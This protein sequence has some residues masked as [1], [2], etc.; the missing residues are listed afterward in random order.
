MQKQKR[1]MTTTQKVLH[2]KFMTKHKIKVSYSF[3]CKHRPFW[4]LAPKSAQRDTCKCII[5][6]NIDLMIKALKISSIIDEPDCDALIKNMCCSI[7]EEKCL[8]RE[9]QYCK[10]K[11]V[12]F[13]E[14]S[15]NHHITYCKWIRARETVKTRKGLNVITVMKKEEV[16]ATP[17]ELINVLIAS[18]R[19]FF[20][21]IYKIHNQYI[22]LKKLKDSTPV[23]CA[24]IHADFSENYGL[25]FNKEV[26][27]MHFGGSR[28][29]ISLHTA[30]I[31]SFDFATSSARPKSICTTSSCLRHD[32]PAAWA[33]FVPLIQKTITDNPFIDTLHIQ[34][35]SPT[36]QY[37]NKYI[38]HMITQ[39]HKEFAQINT[40]TWNYTETGHGKGAADGVG[41]TIK[42]TVDSCVNHGIDVG[43]YDKFMQVCRENIK[44]ITLIDVPE[45]KIIDKENKMPKNLLPFRGTL[46]VHQVLWKKGLSM[47]T[48]RNASCFE[49]DCGIICAHGK[50]LGFLDI[51]QSLSSSPITDTD[52]VTPLIATKRYYGNEVFANITNT[53]QRSTPIEANVSIVARPSNIKILQNKRI[54]M[55]E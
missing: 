1:Y 55:T 15:D 48:L 6:E 35:D 36:S 44:N 27:S 14:F 4:V 16:K 11:L 29:E 12:Q 10:D 34:T 28:K 5:H 20:K 41:G 51:P 43:S 8:R 17:R 25:K 52:K 42:R 7:Y 40:I 47:L 24:V 21:H 3:F 19:A 53:M 39:I 45:D 54:I 13:K 26:Q 49:C 37:R 9:C 46:E 30:I 31:Y 38:F 33:H 23:N 50:H 22:S 18:L 32:A 2:E